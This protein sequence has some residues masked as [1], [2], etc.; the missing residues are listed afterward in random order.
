M[1]DESFTPLMITGDINHCKL[2]LSR[3]LSIYPTVVKWHETNE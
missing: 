1:H 2:C 3:I